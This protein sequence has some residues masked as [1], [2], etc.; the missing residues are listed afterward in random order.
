MIPGKLASDSKFLLWGRSAR[1]TRPPHPEQF[2]EE[3]EMAGRKRNSRQGL[4]FVVLIVALGIAIWLLLV[5]CVFVVREVD[6]EGNTTLSAEDVIRLSKVKLGAR[7]NAV[8]VDYIHSSVESDGRLAFEGLEKKYPNRLI[9]KVRERTQDAMALQAGKVLVLDADGYVVRIEGQLPDLSVPYVTG[10]RVTDYAL[11]R[12]VNAEEERLNA[13]KAV[14]EALKAKNATA[15]VSELNVEDVRT[16]RIVTRTGITVTLGDTQ[17]MENKIVW[18]AGAL[19]DLESRGEISG[20][21]DV[22]SGNK[23]DFLPIER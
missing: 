18:M 21:L 2:D 11:G 10:L 5:N 22:S 15:Y 3:K 17:N 23:A 8:D 13:M 14:L 1:L 12:R 19:A 7:L 4:I 6:V 16:L 20:N 9:L